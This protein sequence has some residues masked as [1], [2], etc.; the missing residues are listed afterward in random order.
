MSLHQIERKTSFFKN[1]FFK[2][3]LYAIGEILLI[4]TG[5]LI[6]FYV[7]K[8][9][10]HRKEVAKAEEYIHGIY[11]DLQSDT[12]TFS[13]TLSSFQ[14]FLDFKKW[15]LNQHS[16]EQLPLE[17]LQFIPIVAEFNDQI[18]NRMYSK[19]QNNDFLGVS[20]Y[21][22]VFDSIYHY[23]VVTQSSLNTVNDWD[24]EASKFEGKFWEYQ[25]HYEMSFPV[26]DTIAPYRQ[27]DDER[28]RQLLKV[29][30]SVEGR[31]YMKADYFRKK[32]TIETYGK[33]RDQAARLIDYLKEEMGYE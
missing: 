2:Y 27:S 20:E 33:V 3:F 25:P 31:N 29:I 21:Q 15:V 30:N 17:N 4:V 19:M 16:L 5:I 9:N 32:S 7:N 18:N 23:Y 26:R 22:E 13:K 6:A 14:P 10:E 12:T 24:N 8:N 1:K 11:L 28:R